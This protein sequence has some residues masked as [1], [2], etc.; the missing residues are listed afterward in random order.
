MQSVWMCNASLR[1]VT[2]TQGA[3]RGSL[4][5]PDMSPPRRVQGL[6]PPSLMPMAEVQLRQEMQKVLRSP[7]CQGISFTIGSF[8][9]NGG[10]FELV[11]QGL[12]DVDSSKPAK[13]WKGNVDAPAT[14]FLP[15]RTN[16]FVQSGAGS[17]VVATG[18]GLGATLGSY[19]PG[20]DTFIFPFSSIG[21]NAQTAGTVV[22]ECV[23]AGFDT[24]RAVGDA[25]DDEAAGRIAKE[26]YLYARLRKDYRPADTVAGAVWVAAMASG[27]GPPQSFGKS[28]A[29]SFRVADNVRLWLHG[30]L[31]SNGYQTLDGKK[32]GADGVTQLAGKSLGVTSMPK[33]P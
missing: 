1:R 19:A 9:V 18:G 21:D 15:I 4:E 27:G 25:L 12:F 5:N 29:Q 8:T 3:L 22:H 26:L 24:Q 31:K 28:P 7:E 6:A 32:N 14:D 30:V 17:L 33:R 16:Y 20:A 2:I 11:A 23:H 13:H 10:L